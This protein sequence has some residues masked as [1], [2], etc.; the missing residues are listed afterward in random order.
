MTTSTLKGLAVAGAVAAALA[1]GEDPSASD[2]S[3]DQPDDDTPAW[4]QR[5]VTEFSAAL[6]SSDA[7]DDMCMSLHRNGEPVFEHQTGT[8]LLPAS[9]I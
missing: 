1:A 4:Q 5:L 9:L 6:Q 2:G 7:P 3:G 8:P